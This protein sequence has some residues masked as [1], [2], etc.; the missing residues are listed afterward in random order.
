V[1]LEGVVANEGDKNIAYM[2]A[3]SVPNVFSVDNG[4]RVE[5]AN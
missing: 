2:R 1:T 4:L 3:S 5:G